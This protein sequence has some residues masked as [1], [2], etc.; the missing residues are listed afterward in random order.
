VLFAVVEI[1]QSLN[2][3]HTEMEEMAVLAEGAYTVKKLGILIIP[4]QREFG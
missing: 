3:P 2:S 1:T 4:C